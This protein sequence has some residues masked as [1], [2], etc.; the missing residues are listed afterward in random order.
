MSNTPIAH[1]PSEL[2][3]CPKA[4]SITGRAEAGNPM[5]KSMSADRLGFMHQMAG[6]ASLPTPM[7][8]PHHGML[9]PAASDFAHIGAY[10]MGD[11]SSSL[12]HLAHAGKPSHA[13]DVGTKLHARAGGLLRAAL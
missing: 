13:S 12:G 6:A 5:R 4:Q 11:R 9:S 1:A 8:P 2:K 3:T 7:S 10:L